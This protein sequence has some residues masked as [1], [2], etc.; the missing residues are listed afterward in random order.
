[1]METQMRIKI[2]ALVE[3]LRNIPDGILLARD[4]DH[5]N[6]AAK[7][8]SDPRGGWWNPY[9]HKNAATNGFKIVKNQ[10]RNTYVLFNREG[11]F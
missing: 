10:G 9:V 7:I 1:M 11:E 3:N 8:L 4:F 2:L 6:P 5:F